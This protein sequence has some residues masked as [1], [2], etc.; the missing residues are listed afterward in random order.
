MLTLLVLT[1]S[2]TET[3]LC[4]YTYAHGLHSVLTNKVHSHRD[5]DTSTEKLYMYE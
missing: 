4:T 2:D 3:D 1:N 5:T